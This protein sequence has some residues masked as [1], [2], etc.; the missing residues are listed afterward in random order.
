[1]FGLHIRTIELWPCCAAMCRALSHPDCLLPST[2]WPV[3]GGAHAPG[4]LGAREVGVAAPPLAGSVSISAEVEEGFVVVSPPTRVNISWRSIVL[5]APGGVGSVYS[6][7]AAV[8]AC[9]VKSPSISEKLTQLP[10]SKLV[11]GT[12]VVLL[13]LLGEG[14]VDE[15]RISSKLGYKET[16]WSCVAALQPSRCWC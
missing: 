3:V 9:S 13:L 10:S 12:V 16:W 6:A 5:V 4:L 2:L 14:V 8:M 1:V 7:G 11:V 15:I